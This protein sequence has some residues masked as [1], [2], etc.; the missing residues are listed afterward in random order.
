MTP[1]SQNRSWFEWLFDALCVA[2]IAGIYPRYIEPNLLFTSRH[3]LF[4]PT[5][6]QSLSGMKILFFSDLHTNQYSSPCFF[7]RAAKTISKL[8]PDLILFSGDLLT[9][10]KLPNTTLAASFFDSL[11]ARFG[12]FACLGNHDYTEYSTLDTHGH[13][14][15]GQ[16]NGHPILQGIKR[17]F[18]APPSQSQHPLTT[19]LPFNQELLKFYSDHN[20]TVLNNETVHIG[21]GTHRINLTGLGDITSGHFSPST[22]YKGYS[23]RVPGIVFAHSPDAYAHLSYFPGDL[24]LFGHTH[25]GQVN[26]PFLWKRITP[27]IDKSLKSGIYNRDDRT[28]FV[29][30][31]LGSTFPFRLFSPPQLVLFELV[32]G[33]RIREEVP[34]HSLLEPISATP[35]YAT[36]RTMKSEESLP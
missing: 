30:R 16:P 3:R 1:L 10:S 20:V 15:G 12:V 22:A 29:T 19:P 35:S 6:P 25:G 5:L 4:L 17:L 23:S 14:V 18:G 27:L 31:G 28:I 21:Y 13:A 34:A 36:Q 8:S 11:S 9:Y 2:S 26:L 32:R 7:R 33:G 24:F